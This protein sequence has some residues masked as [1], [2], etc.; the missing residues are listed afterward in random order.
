MIYCCTQS[1]KNENDS[2]LT[3]QIGNGRCLC[4][5]ALFIQV[6]DLISTQWKSK[7]FWLLLGYYFYPLPNWQ[8]MKVIPNYRAGSLTSIFEFITST[9]KQVLVFNSL[10]NVNIEYL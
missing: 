6:E 8:L 4:E 10:S 1:L 2:V 7:E 9:Q 3:I 5:S